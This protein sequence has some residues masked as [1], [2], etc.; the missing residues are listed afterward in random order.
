MDINGMNMEELAKAYRAN[1]AATEP[2]DRSTTIE[3]MIN[4]SEAQLDVLNQT[5]CSSAR[6][7]KNINYLKNITYRSI[8]LLNSLISAESYV[9]PFRNYGRNSNP[10]Y[11]SRLN[12]LQIDIFVLADKLTY[13]Q[14]LAQILNLENRKMSIIAIL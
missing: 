2:T 10:N 13:A 1:L 11:V 8:V 14:D 4:L 3:A 12:E 7:N 9:P 6:Q 5:I